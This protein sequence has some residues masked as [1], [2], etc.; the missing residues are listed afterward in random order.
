M[1][2]INNNPPKFLERIFKKFLLRR[3]GYC[4]LG[5]YAEEYHSIAVSKGVLPAITWYSLHVFVA[6]LRHINFKIY[7]SRIMIKNY[8]KVA[9]RNILKNKVYSLINISGLTIGMASCFLIYLFVQHELSYDRYHENAERI[10]RVIVK[11]ANSN[12]TGY[13]GSPAPLARTLKEKYP[14]IESAVRFDDF[15]FKEKT[16]LKYG[17]KSFNEDKFFLA[18]PEIFDVFTFKFIKG[19]PATA[20]DGPDRIVLTEDIA[21]K[22]FGDEDP[23]G[24]TLVYE[25]VRD[26]IVSA[27]IENVPENSHFHF[28]LLCSFKSQSDFYGGRNY[29]ES[30]G[31]WNFYT[32]I[33]LIDGVDEDYFREK[34]RTFVK[35]QFDDDDSV[36]EFQKLTD[37]YLRS[38]GRGEIEPVSDIRTV[39]IFSAIAIIILLIACINFMNLYTANSEARAREVGM[40]KVIGAYRKQLISQ[41]LGESMI[42]SFIALP[43]ALLAVIFVLPA[44]NNIASKNIG[45]GYLVNAEFLSSILL[46]TVAVGVI[47]GSYPAFFMS[48]FTPIKMLRGRFSLKNRNFSLRN[49]LVV[50]QFTVSV[51]FIAGTLVVSNQMGYIRNNGL[52]YNKENI[53]NVTIFSDETQKNYP[54]YKD[55]IM[56]NPS[57]LGVTATSF[58]PSVTNWR[59]GLPFEGRDETNSIGFFRMAGDFNIID[60]FEMEI[61]EGRTFDR[62]F[63]TDLFNAHI[64]NEAAVKAIGWDIK[65]AVGKGFG[66][67]DDEGIMKG[68]V[69][70]VV[71][72]F[73]F[74][75]LHHQVDPM[76]VTVLP[77]FFQYVSIR[78]DPDNVTTVLEFLENE[79]NEVNSGYPFEYYFYDEEFDK[80]YKAD[81]RTEKLFNYFTFLAIFVACLGLF[82][83]S[84][85]TVQKRSKEIGIRKVLGAN[86]P[87]MILLLMKEFL[88]MIIIANTLAIPAAYYL[89]DNWLQNFAFK[90]D[91]NMNIFILSSILTFL[92]AIIT[93]SFQVVRGI[94]ANPVKTLRNE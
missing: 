18:D 25:G 79:W 11:D 74:R 26:Y 53:V 46:V 68:R 85:Y 94:S 23:I 1:N 8:L 78:I 72:D 50:I 7:R 24:K 84:S 4:A 77:A 64:L 40:R 60:V 93:I 75:S 87:K 39:Y 51:I 9:L 10:Y 14:E 37:I 70:G 30:W 33:M 22:Y 13:V 65:E 17:E 80:L 61:I 83:L 15:G 20:L 42:Q 92:I 41:F 81:S 69:I 6:L 73:N 19:D 52:G 47:S 63:S 45:M 32:Y 12:D 90:A 76:A 86:F 48:A 5:D 43:L 71:K 49:I 28:D 82:A 38:N 89:S 36:M 27:V 31:A 56:G 34:T 29:D 66:Y 88:L 44:F 59:E 54:L 21:K 58:T 62:N 55:R 67:Q 2:S 57:V 16:M 35:E 91:L 3:T